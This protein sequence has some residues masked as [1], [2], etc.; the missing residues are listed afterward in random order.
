MERLRFRPERVFLSNLGVNLRVCLCSGLPVA[1]AQGLD[2]LDPGQ[3]SSFPA[4]K[5][6]LFQ[7]FISGRTLVRMVPSGKGLF[8][9]SRR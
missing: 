7:G 1:S 2:Y 4:W 3:N 8:V 9:Q 6:F 5:Q